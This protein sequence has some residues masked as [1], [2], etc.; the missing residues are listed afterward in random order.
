MLY[1]LR[2]VE[3][4]YT[5]IEKR[6]E[7][8]FWLRGREKDLG[9]APMSLMEKNISSTYEHDGQRLRLRSTEGNRSNSLQP[10]DDLMDE[11]EDEK[12]YLSW[13]DAFTYASVSGTIGAI[14]V[15][16]AGCTSKI[17]ISA[18][19]GDNQFGSPG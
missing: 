5:W 7:Q 8:A 12:Q 4:K 14:S 18:F 11:E 16:L 17:L 10:V 13:V 2:Q 9:L 15:L 6:V 3:D 19:E 1:K